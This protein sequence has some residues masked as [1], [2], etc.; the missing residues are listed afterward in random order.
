MPPTDHP[1]FERI[2]SILRGAARVFG[3]KGF[4]ATTMR[5]VA[6]ETGAS[7]GSI[8][9][10]FRDK[11][12]VLRA[13]ICRNLGR[14]QDSLVSRLEG[15]ADPRLRLQA[16]VENH[17]AFFA[18]HLDEMRVMSH[19]LDT[20]RGAPGKEVATL[21]KSYTE[22]ARSILAELR[23]DLS[24]DEIQV[25]TLALFGMLNWTYRWYHTLPEGIDAAGLAKRMAA[26]FLDGFSQRPSC[27]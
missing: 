14:V 12:D 10:H 5:E 17:V 7:L 22:R 8:Y 1:N 15:V 2:D 24:G 11:N 6:R 19:E 25:A 9:Y 18:L 26:V 21:R 16:F 3:A 20:L 4:A 13:I 27:H 23:P